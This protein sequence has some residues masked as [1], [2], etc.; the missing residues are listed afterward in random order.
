MLL[1]I[2]SESD[3]LSASSYPDLGRVEEDAPLTRPYERIASHRPMPSKPPRRPP[4]TQTASEVWAGFIPHGHSFTHLIRGIAHTVSIDLATLRVEVDRHTPTGVERVGE[5]RWD[6][7]GLV[8]RTGVLSEKDFQEIE[9]RI[10]EL[11][12]RE[13]K[14]KN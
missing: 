5:G 1:G 11:M 2:G 14:D 8:D 7:A 6:T 12:R 10:R 13:T 4:P 3:R 9:A